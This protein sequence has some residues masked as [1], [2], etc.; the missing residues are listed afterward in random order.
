MY[1][2]TS[3]N[4]VY[5]AFLL[6]AIYVIYLR[7][8]WS[9]GPFIKYS[10]QYCGYMMFTTK[11]VIDKTIVLNDYRVYVYNWMLNTT[12]SLKWT[13]FMILYYKQ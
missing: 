1:I 12:H 5:L 9:I 4:A 2:E 8:L 3:K 7:T 11:T 13:P 6:Y 10:S